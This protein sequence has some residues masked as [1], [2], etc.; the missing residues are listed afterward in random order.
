MLHQKRLINARQDIHSD[1]LPP[2]ADKFPRVA[3][4]FQADIF[5]GSTEA[6]QRRIDRFRVGQIRFNEDLKVLGGTRLRMERN[7]V[8]ADNQIHNAVGVEARQEFFEVVEHPGPVPSE[9]K[10]Q[11]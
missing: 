5:E 1:R 4:F 2:E 8:P 6:G 11:E 3:Q 7:C 9:R 10:L